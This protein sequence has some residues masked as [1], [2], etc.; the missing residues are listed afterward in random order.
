MLPLKGK[1]VTKKTNKG[2]PMR[3]MVD[4]VVACKEYKDVNSNILRPFVE[5]YLKSEV[6]L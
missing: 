6:I 4:M 5:T 3:N 1:C 2:V